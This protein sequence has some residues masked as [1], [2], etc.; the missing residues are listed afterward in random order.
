MQG[1]QDVGKGKLMVRGRHGVSKGG[2]V[3]Q[4]YA[5]G[6]W[7]IRGRQGVSNG[8]DWQG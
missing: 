3:N 4:G 2:L 5:R 7:M 8:A 1:R 6:I